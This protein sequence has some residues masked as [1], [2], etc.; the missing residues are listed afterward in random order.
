[1]VKEQRKQRREMKS[2]RSF[3]LTIGAIERLE[4]LTEKTKAHNRSA[5]VERLIHH[6]YIMAMA[7][8]DKAQGRIIDYG[9]PHIADYESRVAYSKRWGYEEP[10]CNPNLMSGKCRVCWGEE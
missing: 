6:E 5:I 2:V 4:V 8:A 9:E 10:K 7:K 1:M 3:N